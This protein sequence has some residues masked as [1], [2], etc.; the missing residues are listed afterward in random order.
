MTQVT[1]GDVGGEDVVW[2][3][4]DEATVD[5]GRWN[6]TMVSV[7]K[8]EG[9][10]YEVVWSKARTESGEHEFPLESEVL[11]EVFQHSVI[12]VD[13]QTIW[14]TEDEAPDEQAIVTQDITK[15]FNVLGLNEQVEAEKEAIKSGLTAPT[16]APTL[17]QDS[18][19][20]AFAHA[21]EKFKKEF[22]I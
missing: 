18:R 22:G 5:E 17:M 15:G 6:D 19:Y 3:A 9:K 16:D 7:L 1:F 4:I 20:R 2:D 12:S 10:F 8:H 11:P 13:E 14:T 21:Y